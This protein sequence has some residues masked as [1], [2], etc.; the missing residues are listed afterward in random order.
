MLLCRVT[1]GDPLVE[2]DYRGNSPGQFWHQLRTEPKK[3]NGYIYNSVVGESQQNYANAAL[4][5]REYIVF[6]Q[7]QV[8]PEYKVYFKRVK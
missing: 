7:T 2:K 5:L 4:R 6:E 1:M 8:Y 3:K